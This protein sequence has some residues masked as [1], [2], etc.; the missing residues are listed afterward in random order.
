MKRMK[1]DKDETESLLKERDLMLDNQMNQL[2][3]KV[4]AQKQLED[5]VHRLFRLKELRLSCL[6][7][8]SPFQEGRRED[9]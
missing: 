6:I 1:I 4:E 8:V 5:Q 2:K 7:N 3:S 9:Y